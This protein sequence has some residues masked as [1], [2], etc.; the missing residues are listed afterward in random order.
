MNCDLGAISLPHNINGNSIVATAAGLMLLPENASKLIRLRRLSALGV[1]I[2]DEG[3]RKVPLKTVEKLLKKDAIGGG[4]ITL[5]EDPYSEV[6]VQGMNFFGGSYLLSPG[7][8]EHTIADLENLC[9]AYFRS[10]WVSKELQN[11]VGSLVKGLLIVSDMV[12]KR[13][14]LGRGTLPV[15]NE[16]RGPIHI[17]NKSELKQL[18]KATFL[19]HQDLEKHGEWLFAVVDSLA[20]DP[21]Q[22]DD[23]SN[24]ED[25]IE[26]DDLYLYPFLRCP[27]GYQVVLPLDLSIT[28]RFH[29]LHFAFENNKLSELGSSWRQV[30]LNRLKLLCPDAPKSVKLGSDELMDRYLLPLDDKRDIHV[31]LATDPLVDWNNK[32]NGIYDTRVTIA[33]IEKLV[34]PVNRK[35]YSKA[36][37][38]LHL[39]IID[40]PGRGAFWGIPPMDDSDLMLIA[41]SDDIEIMLHNEPTGLLGLFLFAQAVKKHPGDM[42]SMGVLDGYSVYLSNDKSFYFSD[43]QPPTF[44]GIQPTL[45]A[46]LRQDFTV[47]VDRHG[48]ILPVSGEPVVNVRRFYKKDASEIYIIE[49]NSFSYIGFVIELYGECIFIKLNQEKNS[50]AV[51]LQLAE[52]VAYWIWECVSKLNIQPKI[53]EIELCLE[54]FE[55][56][57]RYQNQDNLIDEDAVQIE[58]TS[59]GWGVYF[60]KAFAK[61][62]Q[63]K[64]NYAERELVKAL[65]KQILFVNANDLDKKLDM[66]APEGPK[67]IALVPNWNERPDVFAIDTPAP[68]IR[69]PQITDQLLDDLGQWLRS[70][71]KMVVGILCEE[72]RKKVFRRVVKYYFERL[73]KEISVYDGY[74]ILDFLIDQNEA[75]I[76]QYKTVLFSLESKIACFGENSSMPTE[77]D[78]DYDEFVHAQRANRFLIEYV[79]ACPPAGDCKI[80]NLDYLRLLAI[81]DE[82]IIKGTI[83]NLLHRGLANYQVSI[84]ESGRLGISSDVPI[85][86]AMRDYGIHS[87]EQLIRSVQGK[88]G[89]SD[90]T[91]FDLQD[92]VNR[93]E[94]VMRKEFGFSLNEL[95]NVCGALL[96]LNTAD[97]SIRIGLDEAVTRI[98]DTRNMSLELVSVIL[99]SI[100]LFQRPNFFHKRDDRPDDRP[101]VFNRDM[102]YTRRSVVLQ[103]NDLVFGF[104]SIHNLVRFWVTTLLSGRFSSQVKTKEMKQ[105]ISKNRSQINDAFAREISSRLNHLGIK[106]KKAIEK[107]GGCRI[108]G[109]SKEK[110]G[111][112]DIL[113]VHEP[114]KTIVAIE[115]KD[116]EVART[117]SELANEVE[118][119]FDGKSK[120]KSTVEKHE[121]R[122]EWLREHLDKVVAEFGIDDSL[123]WKVRGFIVTSE[124]LVTPMMRSS[125]LPVLTIND[126]DLSAL[127]LEHRSPSSKRKR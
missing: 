17:P 44:T 19:S 23:S 49:P 87:I 127:G 13:A 113:G 33:E 25:G 24:K 103:G 82:I 112:I 92:F 71:E 124:Q 61:L 72:E 122:L 119:L 29:L 107:F 6:L 88:E 34:S 48:I 54:Y 53:V 83:S 57:G 111:D 116:F 15:T 99:D 39:V 30:V 94:P 64:A 40:S 28:I 85:E 80:N 1:M 3:K 37:E 21:G 60:T 77:L 5:H 59:R 105:L 109:A 96:D 14:G 68:L 46:K 97:K 115:A 66:I 10:E 65:L 31:I 11:S 12:L 108:A 118:K 22:L 114:S 51:G 63:E 100:S 62:L 16:M 104:R 70:N 89:Y 120:K 81:S 98:A 121:R 86:V 95:R 9:Y 4:R 7:V 84:L 125:S 106:T 123:G 45:G 41:R 79:A 93:S 52:C 27:N 67:R 78:R 117:P 43:D 55:S 38:I 101:W 74:Q 110:L 36:Q 18:T 126:L 50:A 91:N 47:G 32:L 90:L 76:H 42:L 75:L 26:F 20:L 102:S 56:W 8:G 69:H 58:P 2:G 35:T 73:K